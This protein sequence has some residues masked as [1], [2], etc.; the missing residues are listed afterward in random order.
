MGMYEYLPDSQVGSAKIHEIGKAYKTVSDL[1][2]DTD[3]D[4]ARTQA[5]NAPPGVRAYAFRQNN[6]DYTYALWAETT[7]DQQEYARAD[8]EFPSSVV[9][10]A[11]LTGYKWDHSY[12]GDQTTARAGQTIRLTETPIFFGADGGTTPNNLAPRPTLTTSVTQVTVGD[13]FEVRI[14]W[15]ED[16]TGLS[17]SDFAV[18][19]ATV[20]SLSGSGDSYRATLEPNGAG[21]MSITLP[22]R[23][24]TDLSGL[25]NLTSNTL[26]L[27]AVSP[28]GGGGG[29]NGIDLELAIR[30]DKATVDKYDF[31]T[32]TS[33]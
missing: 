12:S 8:F 23:V 6:G 13:Q 16:I 7:E 9:G 14:D 33:F 30:S 24:A 15:T 2:T 18:N 19:N 26:N 27:Q 5:L 4:L 17:R 25:D 29:S 22:S 31:V 1:L 32:F 21:N 20:L 3:Y 11:T 10:N 28:G